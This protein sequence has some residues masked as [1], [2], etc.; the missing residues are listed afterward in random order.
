MAAP[1]AMDSALPTRM[2][3]PP[4]AYPTPAA[5]LSVN[6]GA[7]R[8]APTVIPAGYRPGN[9]YDLTP[10][11]AVLRESLYPSQRE[12]AAEQLGALDWRIQPEILNI[13]VERARED[14]APTVRAECV[15]S[16]S[17]LKANTLP[18]V[19]TV[20]RLQSDDDPR[21]RHEADEAYANLSAPRRSR[22]PASRPIAETTRAALVV[23][24]RGRGWR[25]RLS[26]RT[27]KT[28]GSYGTS[29]DAAEM[30]RADTKK[31]SRDLQRRRPASPGSHL[32]S[33]KARPDH[34]A[35]TAVASGASA[36]G[37]LLHLR[38]RRLQ[39]L[40]VQPHLRLLVGVEARPGRHQVAEDHV[41]LQ[42]RPGSPPCRPAPPPSA[43]SSSPGTTPPR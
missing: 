25:L 17:R 3:P 37:S 11:V 4:T 33:R 10:M 1:R 2:L 40:G 5:P 16:L 38:R 6:Y 22:R 27:H 24:H 15:R 14:P 31:G 29:G 13:L 23:V 39:R 21:V 7:A 30:G 28:Y 34:S 41:L 42:A 18:V 26:H 20:K 12:D 43:P 9:A 19:E 32:S 35:V 36:S 8:P